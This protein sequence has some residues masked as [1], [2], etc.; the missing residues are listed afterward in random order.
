MGPPGNMLDVTAQGRNGMRCNCHE[1]T[2]TTCS[3]SPAVH[4]SR[5]TGQ[6]DA[7]IRTVLICLHAGQP[8]HTH[9]HRHT[10]T[11]TLFLVPCHDLR[12]I[13]NALLS[14]LCYMFLIV[15]SEQRVTRDV[16]DQAWN[17]GM[18]PCVFCKQ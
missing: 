3:C 17:R 18:F 14:A 1:L 2:F 5:T 13:A 6:Q 10:H 8:P 15:F 7:H 9:T 12:A 16:V 11:H 4:L